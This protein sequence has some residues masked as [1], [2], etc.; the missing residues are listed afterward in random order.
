[1]IGLAMASAAGIAYA[2]LY[3]RFQ[4]EKTAQKRVGRIVDPAT[5]VE[6]IAGRKRSLQ[7]ALKDFE[8]K[9][10][11]L[12]ERSKRPP[13]S[14][15]LTRA[16]LSWT[17]KTYILV[18][19]GIGVGVAMGAF[20]LSGN[21]F[22]GLGAAVVGFLGLP[23]WLIDHLAKR[24]QKAFVDELPTAVDLIVRGIR[25]GLPLGDCLRMVA[26]ETKDPVRWEFRQIIESQQ[27]GLPVGEAC[28]K[29]YERV[30]VQEANFFGI[31]IA[32]QQKAGG[33]LSEALANLSKVIRDRKKMKAKIIAMSMEAKSSAGIIGSLPL[34][35]GG[36]V[37]LTSPNY[38]MLLFRTT[39]GNV[40]LVGS[41]LV[42]L[43][44][45][46]VMKKMISFDF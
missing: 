14:L 9:Q 24:R 37:Y 10:K 8:D 19:I 36:L 23:S 7:D 6:E 44:G 33:N 28:Q 46:L 4:G 34:I 1:M 18:S 43:V 3:D 22:V 38:I 2:L 11:A 45:I 15:R 16:G 40:I 25:S 32:I 31:V 12:E 39:A 42:M 27:L 29:L 21:P 41:G 13:L 17:K 30:P 20:V 5:K 26:T 35:V